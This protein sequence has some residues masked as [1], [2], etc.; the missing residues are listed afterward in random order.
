MWSFT[1]VIDWKQRFFVPTDEETGVAVLTELLARYPVLVSDVLADEE[2]TEIEPV[3]LR[4]PQIVNLDDWFVPV[5]TV[6]PTSEPESSVTTI[7]RDIEAAES[8]FTLPPF[9]F[10]QRTDVQREVEELQ[11]ALDFG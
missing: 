2:P 9:Y 7:A 4:P 3:E 1:F 10:A 6:E 11:L 8:A 5:A